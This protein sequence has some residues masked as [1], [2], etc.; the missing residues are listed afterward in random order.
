MY[1][2]TTQQQKILECSGN[3]VVVA[4]P[5]SGKT[6]TIAHKICSVVDCLN[7]YEGVA[8]IS[9]TNKASGE[10]REKTK[11]ICSD[12]KNSYFSTID[13]FYIGN[14]IIPFGKRFF[15]I[16]NKKLSV[17]NL[18]DYYSDL[19]SNIL[20]EIE[21]I[22]FKFR[23]YSIKQL[24]E[25]QINLINEL[26]ESTLHFIAQKFKDGMMD[27]RLVGVL[28]NLIFLS[29]KACRKYFASRF[30]Y[31]FIDEF[32][33]SGQNQYLL[34]LRIAEIGVKC[35]AIGDINQSIFRFAK[36]DAKYLKELLSNKEFNKF[37]MNINHRCHPSINVYSRKLLGFDETVV[38]KDNRVFEVFVDGTEYDIGVWFNQNLALIKKQFNLKHNSQIGILAKKNITL[39]KFLERI[40]IP[41]KLFNKTILDEDRSLCSGLLGALLTMSLDEKQT[42]YN[43]IDEY[44]DREI[45]RERYRVQKT[46]KLVKAFR[47]NLVEFH[48][49]FNDTTEIIIKIFKDLC[50]VVYPDIDDQR[51]VLHLEY[52]LDN[53]RKLNDFLPAKDNEIQLMNLYKS[54][55][56]EFEVVVHLDLYQFLLPEFDW[57]KYQDYENYSDS[58]NLHYVGITRAKSA[59]FLMSSSLRY[60]A[61]KD[62]FI[63]AQKSE[64]LTDLEVF[65]SKWVQV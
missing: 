38:E 25:N 20:A 3:C 31:I 8:A 9:Y 35:W 40:D 49:D 16:P 59:L 10:L 64:F 5:G 26:K 55:G 1:K 2:P 4:G 41:H 22:L 18:D 23:D 13:S 51:A 32:Q 30:K 34:F 14:I 46:T 48:Q 19:I 6:T 17:E 12:L 43:F 36:K 15:G 7:W 58:L 60:Q 52:I 61:A 33:D 42:V 44:L 57:I 50:G 56:L 29:S 63:P 65:Q 21:G 39:E 28:S 37:P 62:K 27:L 54:K 11:S 53:K 24:E 45:S 47:E